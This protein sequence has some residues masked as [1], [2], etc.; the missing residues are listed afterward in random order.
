[1]LVQYL[2][3]KMQGH[4]ILFLYNQIKMLRVIDGRRP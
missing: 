2:G 1:M 3:N 4:E